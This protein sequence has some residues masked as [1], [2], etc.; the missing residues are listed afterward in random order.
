MPV[1]IS[2]TNGVTFPDS[3][4]Q[5]AAA[6]PYV[7]KNRIINGNMMIDQRAA[8]ASTS[9][10]ASQTY[11]TCDRWNGYASQSSKFT[12][13]RNLGAVTPPVGY[14]NYLGISSSSAYS[15]AAGDYFL[16]SQKI[17]GFNTSDLAYGTANAKTTTLSFW[18]YSSLTGT[19]GGVFRNSAGNRYYVFS[20]TIS[21]ANTWQ[22]VS[23]TIAGDTSGTWIGGT[24][25]IGLEVILSFGTG[26]TYQGTVGS[27]GST[28]YLA[29][30][31]QIN[32][33]GT[34]GATFYITGVQLEQN[35]SATPFER[36]LYSQELANCQRY[37]EK[38]YAQGTVAGTAVSYPVIGMSFNGMSNTSGQKYVIST[39]K[40]TKRASP[41][42]TYYDIAGTSGKIST[43]DIAGTNTNNVN[44][45]LSFVND[46]LYGAAPSNGTHTGIT[47]DWTAS[48]EL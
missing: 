36:R 1:S 25:G 47:Y 16:I 38:S 11:V 35:T 7:L 5:A 4:L 27:W 10:Q 45:A 22:Q 28:T 29:P 39:F 33:T 24:N 15:I 2:G 26:S 3:S 32:V 14:S 9:F 8:G 37:Y 23:I 42:M 43:L 6:S 21:T 20:Y 13:G 34:S 12:I 40:V 48:I 30:T 31:G 19:F 41:T 17:E 18:V 44:I 46:S